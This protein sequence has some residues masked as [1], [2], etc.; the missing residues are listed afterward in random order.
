[1]LYRRSSLFS[2]VE[3]PTALL[4]FVVSCNNVVGL[5]R[6]VV[7]SSVSAFRFR[8]STLEVRKGFIDGSVEVLRKLEENDVVVA[9]DNG[10]I[11]G[12]VIKDEVRELVVDGLVVDNSELEV[13]SELPVFNVVDVERRREPV[14]NGRVLLLVKVE[15]VVFNVDDDRRELFVVDNNDDDVEVFFGSVIL[16]VFF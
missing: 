1:M 16:L 10:L 15:E 13:K 2:V 9:V 14:S 12:L 5:E 7:V 6:V 11:E 3:G 4:F 8:V